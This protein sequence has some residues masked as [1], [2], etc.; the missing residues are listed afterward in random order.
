[1]GAF[2]MMC[3]MQQAGWF[4]HDCSHHSVLKTGRKQ[5][6]LNDSLSRVY[7]WLQGY[8]LMWWKARHNT[9]HVTTN[10]DVN[11]PDA[12]TSPLFT[13]LKHH[14]GPGNAE[15]LA[16]LRQGPVL[17]A[18][19]AA[20]QRL[21]TWYFLPSLG[22]L[23]LYWR[24]ESIE[25]V[26]RRLGKMKLPALN[27]LLHYACLYA[28][29]RDVGWGPLL[30]AWYLKGLGTGWVVFATHY[31][32]ER[33]ARGAPVHA[34][35]PDVPLSL[36]EQTVRTSRNITSPFWAFHLFTGMISYQVEHHLFPMMPRCHYPAIKPRVE[37]FC[38]SHGLPYREDSFW[39]CLVRNMRAL[40]THGVPS[41]AHID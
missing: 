14:V 39:G 21:Q 22:L 38:K 19:L 32:E 15:K 24:I 36:A 28:L 27:L 35:C 33:L 11:D 30:V 34:E 23:H 9:H 40:D 1:V 6:W 13:Y 8:E 12:K 17:K 37:A 41:L 16:A 3:G 7:G 18:G 20:V 29:Y 10:E 2:L 25:Y 26:F 5:V 4:G 31:A